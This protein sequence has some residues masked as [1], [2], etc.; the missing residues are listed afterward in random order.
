MGRRIPVKAFKLQSRAG[1]GRT[2]MKC[3]AGDELHTLLVQQ[4]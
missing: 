1:K 3:N 4:V 2:G